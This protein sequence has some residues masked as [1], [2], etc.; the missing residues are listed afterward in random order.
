MRFDITREVFELV[1]D[2]VRRHGSTHAHALA[3]SDSA[4]AS[5]SSMSSWG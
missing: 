3:G 4:S 2:F 1:E 5:N